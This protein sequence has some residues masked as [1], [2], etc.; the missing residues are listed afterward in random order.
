[1]SFQVIVP[2][3]DK[4]VGLMPGFFQ[5]WNKYCGLVGM[6]VC[7]QNAP[8]VG[9]GWSFFRAGFDTAQ[10][11][12]VG[13]LKAA[14]KQVHTETVLLILDD[15]WLTKQV[16]V[17]RINAL[18]FQMMAEPDIDKIDLTND[19][20]GFPHENHGDGKQFV[21]SLP[22]AP[23]LTSTQAA[24]WDIEFLKRCL[25]DPSWSPWQFELIGSELIKNT[26][27]K[28]LGCRV[29]AIHYANVMLKGQPNMTE[30]TKVSGKDWRSMADS[31]GGIISAG[32]WGGIPQT[33]ELTQKWSDL[34]TGR[35]KNE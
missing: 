13:N 7:E 22:D 31:D 10:K 25:H 33:E 17:D 5:Q 8:K 20:M 32:D 6:V 27:H 34:L 30:M 16:D 24:L 2:T 21:R 29:P 26:R 19:R 23:Y 15:Y 14:L 4:Y 12:W 35:N 11:G 28:I 3:C 9:A 18:A 1:M